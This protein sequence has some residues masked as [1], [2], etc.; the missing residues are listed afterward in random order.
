MTKAELEAN[1]I[2]VNNLG[3]ANLADKGVTVPAGSTTATIMESIAN[4]SQSSNGPV[5]SNFTA[6]Q[7]RPKQLD[8]TNWTPMDL[9]GSSTTNSQTYGY[10]ACSLPPYFCI[11]SNNG[12]N[13][14]LE[15]LICPHN[16]TGVGL[17][18]FNGDLALVIDSDFFDITQLERIGNSGFA[19]CYKLNQNGDLTNF[20]LP[21]I[22][23]I[24]DSAFATSS[25]ASLSYK[26]LHGSVT[27][28]S[29]GHPVEFIGTNAFRYQT[30]ITSI[31]V[32]TTNG[33][34]LANESG[35]GWGCGTAATFV[36]A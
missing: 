18:C 6:Q 5:Y 19:Y 26:Y 31:T 15:K 25:S 30:Q 10:T 1:I 21:V 20:T 11:G 35:T 8:L 32:Y 13:Q 23:S 12:Y 27:L 2:T 4:I 17:N 24:G 28:G 16:I 29:A 36:S 9:S 33:A 22:V 7:N 34:S 14:Y 3:I